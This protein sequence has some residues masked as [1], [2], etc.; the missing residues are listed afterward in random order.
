GKEVW[1]FEGD[2]Q[3]VANPALTDKYVYAVS[4]KGTLYKLDITNGKMIN[5]IPL[6]YTVYSNPY[7]EGDTVYIYARDHTV[8]AVD[9]VNNVITWNFSSA[10]K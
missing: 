6:G 10:I 4:E 1:Q 3:M 5:S 8:Y 9:T 7:A 2:S